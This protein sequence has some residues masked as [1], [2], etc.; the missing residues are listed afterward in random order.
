MTSVL[1]G[2]GILVTGANRG[3]GLAIARACARAGANLHL[4]AR[5]AERLQRA[6]AAVEEERAS[7]RQRVD[8][9]TCDVER[10]EDIDR[11]VAEAAASLPRFMGLINNAGIYGPMGSIEDQNWDDWTRTIRI[12]LF[13]PAYAMRAVLPH[14][15]RQGYGKIVNLS[16]GGATRPMPKISAYAASKAG[17]VRLTET[18]AEEAKG[19]R[20]FINAL[21]PGALNTAMLDELIDAGPSVIGE[22][23]FEKALAQQRAGGTPLET[24]AQCAVW[25]M[26]EASD[27][28]SGRLI[29]A[30]WDPWR[31]LDE[32]R[33]DL[34][35]SDVYT[36]RRIL[37]RDR[38]F[39]W[40]EP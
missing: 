2:R 5:D 27:G 22:D 9:T 4:T 38:G 6:V 35:G 28:I 1:E 19:A 3:L 10:P 15:R 34:D 12:N 30:V 23:Q 16:G 39:P 17:L 33:V 8:G 26:S 13:G 32:H 36:L 11:A 20:I 18:A 31:A 37:P 40:G 14:F 21:A 24:P 29:S 25:L 7:T